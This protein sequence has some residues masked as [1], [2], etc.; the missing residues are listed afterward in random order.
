MH[1]TIFDLDGTILMMNEASARSHG[2]L[3]G[4]LI[5]K[6]L[7]ELDPVRTGLHLQRFREVA[8]TGKPLL[9]EEPFPVRDGIRWFST[10]L[11]PI[12][13]EDGKKVAI[14]AVAFD[15]TE[16]RQMEDA[17]RQS[18]ER[19]K[20]ALEG[21][22]DSVWDWDVE[23]NHVMLSLRWKEQLGY[24]P[25]EEA[26]G[27]FEHVHPDDIP[28]AEANNLVLRSGA[29][30]TT[31]IEIRLRCKDGSYCWMLA[32]GMVANRDAEGNPTRII[33]TNTN[34]TPLKEHQKQLEH[35]AHYDALT[36]LPNRLLLSLRLQQ[37]VA[38]SQRREQ[39][40]AVVYLDLDGFKEINDYYGHNIGDEL[41]I[42]IS[43]RMKTA[44][45]EGDTLARIGG[46]EFIAVL[47]DLNQPQDCEPVLHRLLQAAS[48]PITVDDS[49]LNVSASIGV[50]IYPGDGAD[51]DQLIRHADQAMYQA[52][53]AGK[54]RFQLFDV[55]HDTKIQ[56][57]HEG[58]ESIRA[59]LKRNEFILHYQPKVNMTTGKIIG[60]EALIRWQHPELGLLLPGRFLPLAESHDLKIQIGEWV[61]KTA[62][63]Q[64]ETWQARGLEIPVSVNIDAYHLQYGNFVAGLEAL[65][66]AHPGANPARI[67]LEI[68][69]TNAF[70]DLQQVAE[71]M[72]ACRALGVSFAL[73]DFGTGYASLTYLKW[74]P[75]ELLKIDQSFVRDMLDDPDDLAIVESVIGLANAFQRHTIA[76]G[77]ETVEH[78]EMLLQLGC[79][80]AQGYG[81]AKPMP[82]DAL[83]G[84]IGQWQP[85]MR[86]RVW[87]NQPIDRNNLPA[88][89]ARVRHHHWL[90]A[91]AH[92]HRDVPGF[93]LAD[94]PLT[95][96]QKNHGHAH[97]GTSPLFA[98]ITALHHQ[99]HELGQEVAVSH[100][101]GETH[102]RENRIKTLFSLHEE[103]QTAL[104][105]LTRN[106]HQERT[107]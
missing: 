86:W 18:E 51:A 40:L 98:E 73:D 59:A 65:L 12:V 96:W 9:A 13:L 103:L 60:V 104:Q 54:N 62:L 99:F 14:Q 41:L 80:L 33:G 69:E 93:E 92:P 68:L 3:P 58:L 89:F 26:G 106:S 32:R 82:A 8:L 36:D 15:I 34:I 43:Q 88:I 71:I 56:K 4:E 95:H 61:I 81:I 37:A 78:G 77:V 97:Y 44:L 5:G 48:T 85:D 6:T 1:T 17:L 30:S 55:E 53:Q 21:S 24:A 23:N 50:T 35:I 16:R 91:L 102:D 90:H 39:S 31:S 25:D 29:E 20:F 63:Q 52:K 47:T 67:N 11:Q 75:A 105:Q 10:Q 45:R 84:W 76:E 100:R 49:I 28:L 22:G 66:A 64:V 7:Q 38:Q 94:C 57:K 2:A 46:D 87:E 107:G 74:L 27:W 70:E 83:A 72:R 19:W 42:L 79:E 101:C